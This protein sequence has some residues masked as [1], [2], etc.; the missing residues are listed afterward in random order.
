[1]IYIRVWWSGISLLKWRRGKA[2]E[3]WS[4]IQK[5]KREDDV[6]K[7]LTCFSFVS[8]FFFLIDKCM[9]NKKDERKM[10]K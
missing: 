1:M 9:K 3:W 4:T 6:T 8:F 7:A 5:E 10:K 2:E